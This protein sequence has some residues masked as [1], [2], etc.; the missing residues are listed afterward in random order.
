MG[1]ISIFG[2]LTL[3][4]TEAFFSA[5]FFSAA[6]V[7]GTAGGYEIEA[8]KTYLFFVAIVTYGTLVNLF[9]N[10][11]LG[12]YNNGACKFIFQEH[13]KILKSRNGW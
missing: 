11:I 12:A 3:V 6:A 5:Q 2:W 4:T 13:S 10:R 7:I 9:G 1:W 8:W